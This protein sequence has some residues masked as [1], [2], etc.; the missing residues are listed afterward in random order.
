MFISEIDRPDGIRICAL[1]P[2]SELVGY[3]FAVPMGGTWHLLNVAVS[4]V[5]K[6][7]GIASWM[8]AEMIERAAGSDPAGY[9]LEVRASNDA[10]QQLY[11]GFGFRPHG[12]RP[13]Y[14]TDNGEDALVMWRPPQA[15]LDGGSRSEEW[16]PPL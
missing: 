4:E 16:S 7:R 15:V 14:Y 3:L 8:I 11:R 9:T 1:G 13:R 10:A 6:R 2:E 12:V 5:H